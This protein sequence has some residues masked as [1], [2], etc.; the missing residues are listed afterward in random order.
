MSRPSSADL[1]TLNDYDDVVEALREHP[2]LALRFPSSNGDIFVGVQGD[3]FVLAQVDEFYGLSV[4]ECSPNHVR[5]LATANDAELVDPDAAVEHF[6]VRDE[7]Q[8]AKSR[9]CSTQ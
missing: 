5:M 4:A 1:P 7:A 9:G 2:Y 3:H 6:R 8:L